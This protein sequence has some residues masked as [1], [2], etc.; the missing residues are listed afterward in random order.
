MKDPWSIGPLE[1]SRPAFLATVS[2]KDLISVRIDPELDL[3][4]E[5]DG[6]LG[7][8]S[9]DAGV[10]RF[11]HGRRETA[12]VEGPDVRLSLLHE[13]IDGLDRPLSD[14]VA[15]VLLPKDLGVFDAAVEAEAA[16]VSELL[17]VGRAL[18]EAAERLVCR[19]YALPPELEDEVVAHAYQRAEESA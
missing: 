12:R 11:K 8:A 14:D 10:L 19:L 2:S 17:A 4:V 16:L 1:I 5:L 18:V 3:T 6:V 15:G 9:L 13:V 7:R